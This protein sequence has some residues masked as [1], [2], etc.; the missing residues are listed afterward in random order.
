MAL[1][2]ALSFKV[3]NPGVVVTEYLR[4]AGVVSV[5]GGGHTGFVNH[6]VETK[7]GPVQQDEVILTIHCPKGLMGDLWAQQNIGRLSSFGV[8]AIAWTHKR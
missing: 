3:K 4:Y 2:N 1:C 6:E 8:K 5:A 7:L